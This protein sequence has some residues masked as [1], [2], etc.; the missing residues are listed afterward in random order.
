MNRSNVRHI[1]QHHTVADLIA[2]TK[3]LGLDRYPDVAMSLRF[4]EVNPEDQAL[5]GIVLEKIRT[6]EHLN[7]VS[8]NPFR[9]TSP[10]ETLGGNVLI[11]FIPETQVQCSIP[12]S[13]LLTHLLCIGKT[14][15][16]KTNLIL[17]IMLQL[18]EL[19]HDD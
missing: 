16:G 5:R 2:T 14:G 6:A 12:T 11:G 15:G 1:D 13:Q 17:L 4:L 9:S 18:L 3:E 10:V 7:L 8:P 19:S